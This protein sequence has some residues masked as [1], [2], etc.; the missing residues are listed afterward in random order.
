MHTSIVE[1]QIEI[2]QKMEE[3]PLS[4]GY[5]RENLI[6]NNNK[7]RHEIGGLQCVRTANRYNMG[8]IIHRFSISFPISLQS[9]I[10]TYHFIVH[11]FSFSLFYFHLFYLVFLNQTQLY[12]FSFHFL[13]V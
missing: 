6:N 9:N 8:E 11:L 1:S 5:S 3:V 4:E 2:K 10:F 13:R 7:K 12:Y